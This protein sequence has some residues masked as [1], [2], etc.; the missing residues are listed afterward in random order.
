MERNFEAMCGK[1]K[2]EK[3]KNNS[4]YIQL[5]NS[6]IGDEEV[7]ELAEVL[8]FVINIYLNLLAKTLVTGFFVIIDFAITS[9]ATGAKTEAAN[10]PIPLPRCCF[11]LL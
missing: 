3:L 1:E 8:Q 6:N 7:K 2:T 11:F 10:A 5:S 4:H 9:M